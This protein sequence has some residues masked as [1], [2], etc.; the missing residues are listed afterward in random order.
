MVGTAA[1]FTTERSTSQTLGS[2]KPIAKSSSR[3]LRQR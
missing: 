1:R 3:M 2:I